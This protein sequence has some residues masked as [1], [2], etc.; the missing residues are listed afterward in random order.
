MNIGVNLVGVNLTFTAL[1]P[2]PTKLVILRDNSGIS[3]IRYY[4]SCDDDT[5]KI[6]DVRLLHLYTVCV[7]AK[8]II[9][10]KTRKYRL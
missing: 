7:D 2:L 6:T 1:L 5:F 9:A 4:A 10:S 3:H 8:D